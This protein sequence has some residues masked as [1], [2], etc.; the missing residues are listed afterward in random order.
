[1]PWKD[2]QD[3]TKAEQVAAFKRSGR[4]IFKML[5]HSFGAL[6]MLSYFSY[7]VVGYLAYS[8]E[9]SWWWLVA[10]FGVTVL[11]EHLAKSSV[12]AHLMKQG[13]DYYGVEGVSREE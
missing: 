6:K 8:E 10:C 9:I 5:A 12:H 4:G 7:F 1:V 13:Y 11:L 3:M 2:I